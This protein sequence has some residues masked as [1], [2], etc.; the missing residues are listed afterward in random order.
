VVLAV[1]DVAT[2][3]Q[4]GRRAAERGLTAARNGDAA[5]A[6]F[7][8]REA[9]RYFRDAADRMGRPTLLPARGVPGVAP[10]VRAAKTLA[11]VGRDLSHAG[12]VVAAAVVPENLD[13]VDGQVNLDEI[14]RITPRLEKASAVL[15]VSF[16]R[17]QGVAREPYLLEPVREAVR[18]VKRQLKRSAGE[19][20]RTAAAAKLAPALFGGD[21]TRKYLL[22]VQNNAESRATG[23]FIGSYGTL[24]AEDGKV[25]VSKLLRTGQWN[26]TLAA[27]GDVP[28][29]APKDYVLRYGQFEPQK[30]LQNVNLS[31]DF[32]TVAHVLMS[33]SEKAGVGPVDGVMAVDP[34]GLAALLQLTG[35]VTVTDW[36]DPINA[37]N[38][39]DVTLRDAYARFE[40][41]PE[42]ADF[43]DDVAEVVV[44]EATTGTLGKPARIAQVLGA[45]SHE[46][47]I[48]LA[49]K[50][51]AEQRLAEHLDA[52]GAA[53]HGGTG[54]LLHV[55][56]QNVSANKLD[57][58][59]RR[60]VDYRVELTP[61][62]PGQPARA[63]ALL[64]VKLANTAPTEGLPQ[65]VAGPYEGQPG[66]FRKGELLS[67]VSAYTPLALESARL[68]GHSI[69]LEGSE[70]LGA[71][72]Y[73]TLIDVDAGRDR[74]LELRFSGPV[75]LGEDGWYTVDVGNQ[76]MLNADQNRMSVTVPDGWRIDKATGGL[77]RVLPQRAART[78]QQAR[79]AKFRVHVVPSG[80]TVWG[81]LEAGG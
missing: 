32:P 18:E 52:A 51:P 70:E 71:N 45:A 48:L 35:P 58:Y 43:L 21:G 73:S 53:P 25:S 62:P 74:T 69:E 5:N 41:T 1:P 34:K 81:R 19:A 65:I 77:I 6:E 7:A 76:P 11:E 15:D 50:R 63:D 39:V 56:T 31:P 22:V 40:R 67:L 61:G 46:G 44:D 14:E 60:N 8:F 78:G 23:G 68:D 12:E 9:S 66:R 10:N 79:P 38:V 30:T 80:T 42:R 2:V 29:D 64:S 24:T 13:V 26:A 47:H 36:P 59:L 16:A 37:E 27:A 49:F 72:V 55:T 33:L 20:R 17:V 3:M 54:D 4:D 28:L 57:Y 75:S